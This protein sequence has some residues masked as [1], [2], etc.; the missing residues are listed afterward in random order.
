MELAAGRAKNA[1]P[2]IEVFKAKG[3]PIERYIAMDALGDNKEKAI[4]NG[5]KRA[6][7][8]VANL[9]E[10]DYKDTNGEAITGID[11]LIIWNTL[12]FFSLD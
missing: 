2:V 4:K 9:I 5:F 10:W 11:F 8:I 1:E 3:I 7:F 6:N 12:C